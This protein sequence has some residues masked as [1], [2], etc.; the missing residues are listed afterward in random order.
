MNDNLSGGIHQLHERRARRTR[1]APQPRH[2]KLASD[3]AITA[4]SDNDDTPPASDDNAAADV[5]P[6]AAPA[7]PP[8]PTATPPVQIA[9]GTPNTANALPDLHVDAADPAAHIVSPTVLSIPASIIKRFE[10]ARAD[11][12]SHTALVLDALRAQV[13]D[14]PALIL[15]RRP[16]PKPGDLFPYR[17]TPGRTAT[18]TPMPLRIRPTKGELNIMKQLTDWS[19]AQIAHQR[20]GTR[21]TN[22]SEMVAAALDAFLPQGRRK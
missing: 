14:L 10:R 20:P 6:P 17:D 2:P 12:P 22:R 16:G 21:H 3:T 13:H 8:P 19:S 7:P 4:P 5:N 15:N 11:S 9:A 18:D 1:Q